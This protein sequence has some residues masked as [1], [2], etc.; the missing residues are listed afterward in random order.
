VEFR[1]LGPLQVEK[2][3]DRVPIGGPQLETALAVLLLAGGHVVPVPNMV[4]ALWDAEPPPT[5]RHQ[6]HK[7]IARLR[8]RLPGVIV[9][10]GPGYRIDLDSATL[11]ADVFARRASAGTA[12][13]LA[14]ALALWRGPALAGIESRAIRGP[15]AALDERRLDAIEAL[16]DLRLAAGQAAGVAAE[17]PAVIAAHPLRERLRA[18]LM[19]AL[20][21]CGRQAEAHAAYAD[22]R[23]RLAEE[24]GLDPGPELARLHQ[25]LLRADPTI[26]PDPPEAPTAP[27]SL[28]YD[29]PDFTGRNDDLAAMMRYAPLVTIDGMAGVG[30]T[31][32]A[33]HAAHRLAGRYPDGQLFCDLHGHTAGAA[34][35]PPEA[36][37]GGLLQMLGVPVHA[38][39]EGLDQ[40]AARWRAEL[41]G[42]RVL[43]VLDNAVSAVQVR[44]LLPGSPDCLAIV[45]SRRR[46]GVLDG[47]ASLALDPLPASD[48]LRMFGAVAGEARVAAECES[49]ERVVALCGRLPLALRIAGTRLAHRRLWTIES[50][51]QRLQRETDRLD[52]LALADRGVGSAFALSYAQLTDAQQRM[53][54]RLGRH[55]GSDFDAYSVAVLAD[56]D[57]QLAESLLEDLVDA[58][59]LGHAAAGRYVFHDLLRDYARKLAGTE[60]SESVARLHDYYLA[61][62][63]TAGDL[64]SRE[65]RRFEPTVAHPP[66]QL[67]PLTDVDDAL[68][69][70]VAEEAT[71]LAVAEAGGGWQLPCVLR[72]F[73]EHRGHFAGWRATHEVGL[74]AARGDPRGT[75]LL[76]FN[77]GALAMWTERHEEGIEQ[78]Q[79]A[80]AAGVG[81]HELE[82]TALTNMGMLAHLLVRDVEAVGYVRRALAIEHN[83]LRTRALGWNNLALAEGRL[84]ERR[85]ALAHHQQALTLARQIG[86]PTAER[87]ILLGLGETSL[88]YGLPAA[89]SFRRALALAR[90]G[91]FRMQEALALDG[92]AHATAD[93]RYWREALVIF[94][95]LGVPRAD[96]VRRHLAEP[97]ARACD[98][99]PTRLGRTVA[100]VGAARP[101]RPD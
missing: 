90:T 23:I 48:A 27:N 24:L 36:A 84:G 73:F 93:P 18:Q 94:H 26:G 46:L 63:T 42:R 82:A 30:K 43:V 64:I 21:R 38:I 62:A 70:F 53:F 95:E 76:R 13:E 60:R 14:A 39:P 77:L 8:N 86:S 99:C 101:S 22:A 1:V 16:M 7:V 100:M 15:A 33:V 59:L 47:A 79:L 87:G 11:D 57:R 45:T 5:A 68:A 74:R 49:A 91:R 97:D 65:A 29:L 37:L 44:P 98:L 66:A 4:D 9:T 20:Y 19:V 85:R 58:H 88:R 35:V 40:R 72:A 17:L 2:R 51:A 6:V 25:R 34:A 31:A 75:A 78:F 12:P 89:E 54:R 83:N 61:A 69:W 41:A 81:D 52:E 28:P 50:L 80:V 71:L 55:P 10:D 32:L 96:A 3:G 92:L 67:P 56:L